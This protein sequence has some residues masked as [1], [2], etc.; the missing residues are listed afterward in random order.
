VFKTVASPLV[1]ESLKQRLRA[2]G[3]D[4]PRRWGTLSAHAMLCHLGDAGEMVLRF[5]PRRN[6]VSHRRKPLTK[7]I[8]LWSPVR[9]PHGWRTNPDQDPNRNGTKPS[10][11]A[12]DRA[13]VILGL[14]QLAEAHAS[15]LEPAHG[16]FGLMSVTDWQRW[17]FKHVDHHLRQFGL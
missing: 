1:L 7:A 13:R 3:V 16:V 9:W 12:A 15:T 2:L 17:A 14:E 5:R 10:E 4:T 8:A 11:F 6:Q